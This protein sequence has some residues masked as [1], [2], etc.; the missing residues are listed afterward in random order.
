MD[1]MRE[2]APAVETNPGGGG[3][4]NGSE[5][6]SGRDVI[7]GGIFREKTKRRTDDMQA[8]KEMDEKSGGWSGGSGGSGGS[9]EVAK[10]ENTSGRISLV[11]LVL[12]RTHPRYTGRMLLSV[13]SVNTGAVS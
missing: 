4:M 8:R 12:F 7:K 3:M 6:E 9:G 2:G 5:G 1:G 13:Y 11:S 10:C